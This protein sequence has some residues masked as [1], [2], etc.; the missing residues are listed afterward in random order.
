MSWLALL[1]S[2]VILF[3]LLSLYWLWARA[4]YGKV[5]VAAIL[6]F[7]GYT[8]YLSIHPPDAYYRAEF[9][10]IARFP[11]PSDG[12]IQFSE[13]TTSAYSTYRSCAVISVS[14]ETYSALKQAIGNWQAEEIENVSNNC[15]AQIERHGGASVAVT[16]QNRSANS[17]ENFSQWGLLNDGQSVVYFTMRWKNLN[18]V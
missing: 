6:V 5:A 16:A 4:R 2:V 17:G 9:E 8:G 3:C 11:F 1:A 15:L 7:S 18:P 10:R 12:K 14:E 13:I